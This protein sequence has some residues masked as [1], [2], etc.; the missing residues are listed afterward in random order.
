MIRLP[1]AKVRVSAWA[2]PTDASENRTVPI[3]R[4]VRMRFLR[5]LQCAVPR[6]EV[7]RIVGT[8]TGLRA[9]PPVTTTHLLEQATQRGQRDGLREDPAHGGEPSRLVG[10]L[11]GREH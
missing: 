6:D 7:S 9:G 8:Y 10:G 4:R 2:T 5:T 3:S 11:R 1:A